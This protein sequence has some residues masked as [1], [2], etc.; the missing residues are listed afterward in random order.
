MRDADFALRLRPRM[1]WDSQARGTA[2]RVVLMGQPGYA[3]RGQV[4]KRVAQITEAQDNAIGR[5]LRRRQH[6]AVR[7]WRPYAQR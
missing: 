6:R 5:A 4:K 3:Q 2:I 7:G 1:L